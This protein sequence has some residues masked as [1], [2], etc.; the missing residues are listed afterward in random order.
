MIAESF[1]IVGVAFRPRPDE[2]LK[3]KVLMPLEQTKRWIRSSVHNLKN[4]AMG[5]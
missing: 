1:Q 4:K 2:Y 5:R 3:G